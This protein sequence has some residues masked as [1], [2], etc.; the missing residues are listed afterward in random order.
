MNRR[1]HYDQL[2]RET[3]DDALSNV[4]GYAA[5][6]PFDPGSSVP[7]D[8]RYAALPILTKQELRTHFPLGF[9]PP[10]RDLH[11]GLKNGEVE[12]AKT[13]G[14]TDDEVTLVFHAPWWA[15]SEQAAWQLNNHARHIATGTHREVVLASPRCVGP[16]HTDHPLSMEER[17]LGRHLYLNQQVNPATWTPDDIR[18]MVAELNR[19]QP[20]ILEA[21]PAYLAFFTRW[22]AE[23]GLDVFQPQLIFLTYSFPSRVY[24]RQI[25]KVFTA[26]MVS[27]YGSTETGH[28]FMECEAGRLH[29]NTNHCRVDFQPWLPRYGGPT[30]GRMLVTVFHNPW[31]AVLRFDIGDVARLDTRGPCPCG[32]TEGL[33]LASIDGRTKDVT[34]TG[35]G[36]A[37][38]VEDLDVALAGIRTLTG[39]QLDLPEPMFLRLRILT[40]PNAV[41]PTRKVAHEILE[42]IYGAEM[43]IEVAAV[44]SLQP[45]LSGKFRFARA[46]F[47]VDHGR[48]WNSP[49]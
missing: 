3:L 30:L 27:S 46:A 9:I 26:P 7:V 22:I 39:W 45:E 49:P 14:S 11:A 12:Y 20:A 34:F 6:R 44:P 24:L 16:G 29:Q 8:Q 4:P 48:L 18:R 25:R 41:E 23:L 37:V 47:P 33:T 5:W 35:D 32:R 28:V 10:G 36:R 19:Y 17:I 13:S 2:S 40:E 15:S 31:F 21:D 1:A 38:T 42:W 43:R